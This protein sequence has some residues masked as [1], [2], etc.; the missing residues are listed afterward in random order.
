MPD[1][2]KRVSFYIMCFDLDPFGDSG[3]KGA[4]IIAGKN[5]RGCVLS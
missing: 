2:W 3:D 1:R 5:I 4:H